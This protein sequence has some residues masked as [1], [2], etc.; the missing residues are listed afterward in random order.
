MGSRTA[1]GDRRGSGELGWYLGAGESRHD[2]GQGQRHGQGQGQGNP[3]P[4]PEVIQPLDDEDIPI[5]DDLGN[6]LDDV[7]DWPASSESY[8]Q[9]VHEAHARQGR[10]IQKLMRCIQ[11]LRDLTPRQAP[12]WPKDRISDEEW[13]ASARSAF[14]QVNDMDQGEAKGLTGSPVAKPGGRVAIKKG[15][16]SEA[17]GLGSWWATK[18]AETADFELL[19]RLLAARAAS[20]LALIQ[21]ESAPRKP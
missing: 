9:E 1:N 17:S 21:S 4:G 6:E 20:A 19:S 13:L 14:G 3:L 2:Q 12:A 15:D 11:L 5:V 7:E 10:L 16:V 18:T 8:W